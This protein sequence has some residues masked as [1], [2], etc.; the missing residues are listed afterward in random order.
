VGMFRFRAVKI[1]LTFE[2]GNKKLPL[3]LFQLV[4]Q[5]IGN[6]GRRGKWES[7]D[8]KAS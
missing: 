8:F 3:F 6:K 2:V 1:P 5:V 7:S 4:S